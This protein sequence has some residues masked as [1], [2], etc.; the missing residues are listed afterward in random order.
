VFEREP[1]IKVSREDLERGERRHRLGM[2]GEPFGAPFAY[3]YYR[4]KMRWG[5]EH[6]MSAR[7]GVE[8]CAMTIA[9][10]WERLWELLHTDGRVVEPIVTEG[11]WPYVDYYVDGQLLT[12]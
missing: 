6:Y 1:A 12:N 8:D 10:A 11:G 5:A 7:G 9:W 3:L 4:H 2:L